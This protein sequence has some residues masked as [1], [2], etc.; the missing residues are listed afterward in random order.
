MD[1]R[2]C[3]PIVGLFFIFRNQGRKVKEGDWN[4]LNRAWFIFSLHLIALCLFEATLLA[5]YTW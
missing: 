3:I 5:L 4:W 1:K 2:E